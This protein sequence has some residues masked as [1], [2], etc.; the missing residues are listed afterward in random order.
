MSVVF[1]EGGDEGGE[2][3]LFGE[4]TKLELEDCS[5]VRY[6]VDPVQELD[7]DRSR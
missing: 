4:D 5:G 3:E 6:K 7:T 1:R 2:R